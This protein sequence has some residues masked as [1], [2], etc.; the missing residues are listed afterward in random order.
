M[1][2]KSNDATPLRPDGDRFLNAQIV[3]MNL[4]DFIAQI[5]KEVSWTKG[6]RN[7]LTIFKSDVMTVVLIGLKRG[8]QL[9]PHQ[10]EGLQSIQ[11][12]E[13]SIEFKSEQQN[14]IIKK[15][16]I[17]VVQKEILHTFKALTDS[18]ILFTLLKNS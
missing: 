4:N 12:L 5:K 3:E 6:D 13:G 14:C 10:W 11:V 7:S 18:F 17:I 2:I 1:E 15:R 16:Q 9:K 8:A